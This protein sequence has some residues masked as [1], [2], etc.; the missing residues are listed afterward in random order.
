MTIQNAPAI[1]DDTLTA[2]VKEVVEYAVTYR[3]VV[4]EPAVELIERSTAVTVAKPNEE[5]STV[6]LAAAL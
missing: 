1:P 4:G 6:P 2:Y 5:I 3:G